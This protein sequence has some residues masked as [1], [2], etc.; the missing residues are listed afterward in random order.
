ML[1]WKEGAT[2]DET[3]ETKSDETDCVKK[4]HNS[5]TM[6][7]NGLD[8]RNGGTHFCFV[9]ISVQLLDFVRFVLAGSNYIQEVSY[10]E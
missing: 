5:E 8:K 9:S 6:E 4:R 10:T 7:T 3:R 1:T 2:L